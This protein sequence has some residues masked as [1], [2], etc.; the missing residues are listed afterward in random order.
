MFVAMRKT[1]ER[2]LEPGESL[3]PSELPA[4]SFLEWR[5]PL[6]DDGEFLTESLAEVATQQEV[7]A[8]TDD[9][10]QA[11]FVRVGS[12]S[13][14]PSHPYAS[15]ER[16]A[17]DGGA[18]RHKFSLLPMHWGMMCQRHQPEAQVG[19]WCSSTSAKK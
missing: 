7:S 17:S 4:Q 3:K 2:N 1:W 15:K 18:E 9:T 6:V 12:E 5:N 16:N 14:G 10:T 8:R 19:P 11:D 13:G